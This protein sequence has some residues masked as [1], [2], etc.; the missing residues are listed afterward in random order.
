MAATAGVVAAE[1]AAAAA[2]AIG[3]RTNGIGLSGG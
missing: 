2:A 3:T 1:V